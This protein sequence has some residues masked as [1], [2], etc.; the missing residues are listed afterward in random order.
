MIAAKS[1]RIHSCAVI[2]MLMIL[3]LIR[4][5]H[6]NKGESSTVRR[7]S[8]HVPSSREREHVE[9]A[10]LPVVLVPGTMLHTTL[11]SSTST[12]KQ[13]GNARQDS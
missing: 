5:Q 12:T 8:I 6:E 9:L 2:V 4:P 3:S 10:L 1:V 11:Y 13:S 7:H